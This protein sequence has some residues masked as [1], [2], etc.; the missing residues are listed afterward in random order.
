[1][2]IEYIDLLSDISDQV[3]IKHLQEVKTICRTRWEE[4]IIFFNRQI[5]L[6]F[7]EVTLETINA[8][9]NRGISVK[10]FG[11]EKSKTLFPRI[12]FLEG[13]HPAQHEVAGIKCGSNVKLKA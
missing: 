4:N 1:M 11:Q 12:V 9:S 2:V 13:D 7:R 3:F 5:C 6:K 8:A 10:I